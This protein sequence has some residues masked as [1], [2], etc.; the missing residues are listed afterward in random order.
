MD[1]SLHVT[2][3]VGEA[4][5]LIDEQIDLDTGE[6]DI[7]IVLLDGRLATTTEECV[8]GRLQRYRDLPLLL[9]VQT[10]GEAE[11]INDSASEPLLYL[12][13]PIDPDE[14]WDSI[15]TTS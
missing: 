14:I 11:I 6:C 4:L 8:L 15:T 2:R 9:L 10:E 1:V 13:R 12:E 5:T 3:T 7:D